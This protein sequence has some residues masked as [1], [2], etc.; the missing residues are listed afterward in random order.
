MARPS[1][2]TSR[3]SSSP[4]TRFRRGLIPA[5][6]C[7]PLA[8]MPA[9]G[10]LNSLTGS[11][12]TTAPVLASFAPTSMTVGNAVTLTGS[13]FTNTSGVTLDGV[14]VPNWVVNSDT[15]ITLQVP[16]NAVTGP[17]QVTT[18]S[19]VAASAS[20]FTVIPLITSFSPTSGPVGTVVTLLGSGFVGTT[21][22]T[23]GAEATSLNLPQVVSANELLTSVDANAT[24]GTIQVVASGLNA[25]SGTQT[26]TVTAQ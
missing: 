16:P 3:P 2:A 7:L 24:T 6:L 21:S 17:L 19:G 22:A 8:L 5:L 11:S 1:T 9:C 13:G 25:S 23:I 18:T 20:N 12:T 14:V 15:Q 10:G 26:F 4:Q